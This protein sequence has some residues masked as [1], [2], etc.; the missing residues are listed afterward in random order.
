M[1]KKLTQQ[2]LNRATLARQLL[3]ERHGMTPLRAIEQLAGMQAQLPRPPFV[4]LWSR[5]V[6]FR[7]EQLT[8]LLHNRKVVRATMMRCTIHLMSTK[9]YLAL[10]SA[11]QP[12]LTRAMH[13]ALRKRADSLDV[14]RSVATARRY[15][16]DEPHTFE[17]LRGHLKQLD[18]KCDERACAFAVR[19][20]LPLAMVPTD[21][22][23][24][25]PAAASFTPADSWIG[26]PVPIADP[27]PDALVRRYLGA[28]GPA[29]VADAQSWSGLSGL[30]EVFEEMRP[31]L[32]VFADERGRELFDLPKAPLPSARTKAPVRFLPDYDNLV[33]AHDDRS[34]L[35]RDGDRRRICLPNLRVQPTFLVDGMVGGTWKIERAKKSA[36]LVITPFASVAKAA[37]AELEAEG[38]ALMQFVE[39]DA[40]KQT[41][42]FARPG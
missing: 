41:V 16:Q 23:W 11:V 7:R 37:R 33:L 26:K 6:G 4:G 19:T 24:G 8:R 5:L 3:L 9:E 12:A 18:P 15:L 38:T 28:F 35:M 14:D 34:R 31:K 1:A 36:T 32:R 39:P 30:R 10:R 13:S 42:R 27:R 21:A 25:Y 22:A 29:S 17:Q 40:A 20:H 2:Q